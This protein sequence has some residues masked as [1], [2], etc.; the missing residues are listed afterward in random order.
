MK[1]RSQ[2]SILTNKVKDAIFIIFRELNLPQISASASPAE[3]Y[4]WK[5]CSEVRKCYE[6]LSKP[7]S[8]DNSVTYLMKIAEQAFVDPEKA[9]DPQVAYAMA[10]CHFFLNPENE[11]IQISQSSIKGKFEEFLVSFMALCK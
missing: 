6:S 9:T 7:T 4:R 8:A 1:H 2:R 10:V 3:I 5:Q 11:N